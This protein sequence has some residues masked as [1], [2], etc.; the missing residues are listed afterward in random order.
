MKASKDMQTFKT[1]FS[2]EVYSAYA[3]PCVVGKE[4][5]VGPMTG[6]MV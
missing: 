3:V 5:V 4:Y 6:K 2:S 1:L